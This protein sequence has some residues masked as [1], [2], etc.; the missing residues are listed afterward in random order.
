VKEARL[1]SQKRYAVAAGAA[2]EFPTALL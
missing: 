2:F 1:S